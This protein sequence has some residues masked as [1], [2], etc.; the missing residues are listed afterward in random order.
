MRSAV[1]LLTILCAVS[2]YVLAAPVGANAYTLEGPIWPGQPGSH[3]CCAN[4][5]YRNFAGDS[6]DFNAGTQ[7]ANAWDNSAAFVFIRT[8]LTPQ[9]DFEEAN[10]SGVGWDG[11]TSWSTYRG[12]NGVTYFNQGMTVQVNNYYLKNY[13]SGEAQSVSTHEFGHSAGLGHA[14]G[15]VI[16]NGYTGTRWGTCGIDTPRSDD[17]NG[18]DALY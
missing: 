11:L 2:V 1:K 4:L 5:T 8:S 9:I 17:D 18:V 16:M 10:N 7:G 3:T 15:C 14:G 6:K 13:S 12:G